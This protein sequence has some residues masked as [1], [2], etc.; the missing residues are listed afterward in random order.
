MTDPHQPLDQRARNDAPDVVLHVPGAY[1]EVDVTLPPKPSDMAAISYEASDEALHRAWALGDY[2][3]ENCPHC[4]RHRLCICANGKHRCEKCD[5][6][7][8]DQDY[9]PVRW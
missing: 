9:A 4:G 7:P 2:V 6:C 8:E 3:A 5:W 1:V